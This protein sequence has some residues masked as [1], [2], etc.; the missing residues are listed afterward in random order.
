MARRLEPSLRQNRLRPGFFAA[1]L[2]APDM[3]NG[4][5]AP[6]GEIEP[7]LENGF[8]AIYEGRISRTSAK[9]AGLGPCGGTGCPH[10]ETP[11]EVSGSRRQAVEKLRDLEGT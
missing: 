2:R 8:T 11:K 5:L 7:D 6:A 4:G 9:S 10:G 1:E 3:R